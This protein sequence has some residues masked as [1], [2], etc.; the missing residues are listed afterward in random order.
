MLSSPTAS[1][2]LQDAATGDLTR[3]ASFAEAPG[4]PETDRTSIPASLL[5]PWLD[6]T[7]PY[8][9]E[10]ADYA[11]IAP[12]PRTRTAASRSPRSWSTAAGA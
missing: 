8:Y 11:A 10:A 3:L 5:G 1:L 2:W 4:A 12:P 9:I 6:R 7:D